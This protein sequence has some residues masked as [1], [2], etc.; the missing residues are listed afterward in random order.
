MAKHYPSIKE[1]VLK[2][3]IDDESI[4]L[5]RTSIIYQLSYKTETDTDFLKLAILH[6]QGSSEFFINKAIGWAL[7]QY[8]KTDPEWVRSFIQKY[9]LQPLSLKEASKYI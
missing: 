1:D 3:W 9:E 8:S 6:N 5:R 7:R 4:W 2:S